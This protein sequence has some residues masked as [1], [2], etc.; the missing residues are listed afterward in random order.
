MRIEINISTLKYKLLISLV[1]ICLFY[2]IYSSI[3]NSEFGRS[4]K[5]V[6]DISSLERM[7]FTLERHLLFSSRKSLYPITSRGQIL[8]ITHAIIA[9]CILVL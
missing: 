8:T 7:V 9:W 5:T 3:P 1:V 6:K 2:V 4:D